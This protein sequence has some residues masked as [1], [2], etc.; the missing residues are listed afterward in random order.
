[1]VVPQLKPVGDGVTGGDGPR[2]GAERRGPG[3][4]RPGRETGIAAG[5]AAVT[6]AATATRGLWQPAVAARKSARDAASTT[7]HGGMAATGERV[8]RAKVREAGSE[9][10]SE[11]EG[12]VYGRVWQGCQDDGQRQRSPR[13]SARGVEREGALAQLYCTYSAHKMT[14][15]R[16]MRTL[17]GVAPPRHIDDAQLC[18]ARQPRRSAPR[19]GMRALA[20]VSEALQLE[21]HALRFGWRC[22]RCVF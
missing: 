4:P 6:T 2:S 17:E 9:S 14:E 3:L 21:Q 16:N 20:R 22:V 12:V 5:F 13:G 11:Q 7:T 19:T 10:V 8:A 1:M 15:A 18:G